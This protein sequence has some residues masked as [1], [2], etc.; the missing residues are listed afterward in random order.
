MLLEWED[1]I[2]EV[3]ERLG[4]DP[5]LY[6]EDDDLK[7]WIAKCFGFKNFAT[8]IALPAVKDIIYGMAL[9]LLPDHKNYQYH[10]IIDCISLIEHNYA[11][12][13]DAERTESELKNLINYADENFAVEYKALLLE[14][15]IS[16][17]NNVKDILVKIDSFDE[18]TKKYPILLKLIGK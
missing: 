14:K 18:M 7:E 13:N 6:N 10:F 12:Y 1:K 8:F 2:I 16:M 5:E 9:E 3:C 15:L 17:D 4:V 11:L